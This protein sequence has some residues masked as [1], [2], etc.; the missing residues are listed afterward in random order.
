MSSTLRKLL[1]AILGVGTFFGGEVLLGW[2]GMRG[3]LTFLAIVPAA[4]VYYM[5]GGMKPWWSK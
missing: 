3:P 2:L 4:I 5:V 1:G